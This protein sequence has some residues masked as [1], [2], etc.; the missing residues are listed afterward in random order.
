MFFLPLNKQPL[1]WITSGLDGLVESFE[2]KP[3]YPTSGRDEKTGPAV[4]AYAMPLF[5]GDPKKGDEIWVGQDLKLNFNPAYLEF[6]SGKHGCKMACREKTIKSI[7]FT[8]WKPHMR[9]R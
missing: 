9:K 5:F 8:L 2:E 3:C 4:V 6:A 1:S 7:P